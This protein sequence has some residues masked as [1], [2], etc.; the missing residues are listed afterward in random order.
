MKV[1]TQTADVADAYM[2][3]TTVYN[4]DA[5]LKLVEKLQNYFA[6][7]KK[8]KNKYVQQRSGWHC[9]SKDT[10]Q[11]IV[12]KREEIS[13]ASYL[14]SNFPIFSTSVA[15]EILQIISN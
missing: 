10:V 2:S 12:S 3:D 5:S 14:M 8:S 4:E 1:N 6:S 13:S 15:E 11:D 9:I 7:L